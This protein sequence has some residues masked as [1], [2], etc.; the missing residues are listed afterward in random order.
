MCEWIRGI[1]MSMYWMSAIER[2]K[3]ECEWEI[4]WTKEACM[5]MK[6]REWESANERAWTRD[7]V[8]EKSACEW[9]CEREKSACDWECKQ[10]CE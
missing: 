5:W 10:E 3:W 6:E 8:R 2:N 9:E 7:S 4:V 1:E